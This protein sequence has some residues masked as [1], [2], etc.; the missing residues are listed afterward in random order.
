[1][2]GVAR[3]NVFV[4]HCFTCP[5]YVMCKQE[6]IQW[7]S[8]VSAYDHPCQVFAGDK[9]VT[10]GGYVGSRQIE[11]KCQSLFR[12]PFSIAVVTQNSDDSL[13]TS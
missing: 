4:C 9:I 6:S 13:C 11:R 5:A 7:E 1:M 10:A 8:Q 12:V 3:C 2:C